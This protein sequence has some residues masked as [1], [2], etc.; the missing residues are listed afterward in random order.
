MNRTELGS[1]TARGG[2]AN[3]YDIVRKFN[4][5]KKDKTAQS[6]LIIM[7]YRIEKLDS[8]IAIQVPTKIKKEDIAN[9][10]VT[11]EEY[12]EYVKFKKA[13]AQIRI[14]IK[15]GNIIKIENISLKKANSDADY[16][17][18]DKRTVDSY[19]EMW[20]FNDESFGLKC[21]YNHK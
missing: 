16:N 18:I 1:Q 15:I 13:D 3:E 11:E 14:I 2:F 8:V 20:G 12:Y 6:W 4:N 17:Q 7:G 10:S 21:L 5:W 19:K 9:F